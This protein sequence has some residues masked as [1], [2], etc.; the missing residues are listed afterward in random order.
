MALRIKGALS[1]CPAAGLREPVAAIVFLDQP[2]AEEPL[3]RLVEAVA[4]RAAEV[5][6]RQPDRVREFAQT[7][8]RCASKRPQ[9]LL[10]DG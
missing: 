2:V 6:P 7:P 5:R 8:I 1:E 9:Q 3:D 4:E 10:I